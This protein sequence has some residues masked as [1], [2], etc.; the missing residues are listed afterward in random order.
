MNTCID[1][2]VGADHAECDC[3]GFSI[4]PDE[5][6]IVFHAIVSIVVVELLAYRLELF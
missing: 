5:L 1:V 2:F 6:L 4:L 3:V